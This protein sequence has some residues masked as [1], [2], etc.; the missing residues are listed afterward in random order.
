[1]CEYLESHAVRVYNGGSAPAMESAR[2]IIKHIQRGAVVDGCTVRSIHRNQWSRLATP[3]EV[4]AGLTVLSDYEWVTIERKE[5]DTR[6]GRPSEVIKIN[7][8]A[9]K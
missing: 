5:S 2:E 4:K 1:M 7:P 9:K 8:K 3:E 6:G